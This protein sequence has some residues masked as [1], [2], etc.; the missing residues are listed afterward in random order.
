VARA[1]D[2]P[3]WVQSSIKPV[4]YV[5]NPYSVRKVTGLAG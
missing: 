5:T 1:E 3:H 2:A 4:M